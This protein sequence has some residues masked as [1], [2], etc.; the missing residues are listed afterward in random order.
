MERRFRQQRYLTAPE[1]EHLARAIGLTPTQI[2]IWFQNHRYKTK[3]S[4][5]SRAVTSS[6]S[7]HVKH[8]GVGGGGDSSDLDIKPDTSGFDVDTPPPTTATHAIVAATPTSGSSSSAS[9]SV[10]H[11]H[12]HHH[13]HPLHHP[14]S[15]THLHQHTA[16]HLAGHPPPPPPFELFAQAQFELA[17]SAVG[18]A[19]TSGHH[20]AAAGGF[21]GGTVPSPHSGYSIMHHGRNW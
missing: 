14:V 17:S 16:S 18:S 8:G 9:S 21:Y 13:H 3:K 4:D 6:T 11:H 19:A 7:T 12:H 10:D 20:F 5:Q 15:S 1:R 2:K